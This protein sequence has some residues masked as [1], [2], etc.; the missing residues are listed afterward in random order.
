MVVAIVVVDGKD[1]TDEM[2]VLSEGLKTSK[3]MRKYRHVTHNPDLYYDKQSGQ[4]VNHAAQ[5]REKV[6]VDALRIRI[7]EEIL[8]QNPLLRALRR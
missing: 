8:N 4:V 7:K 1:Y 6:K 2:F 5:L 3:E